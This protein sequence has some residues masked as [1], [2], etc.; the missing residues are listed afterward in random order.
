[1]YVA[2]THRGSETVTLG[3]FPY[4]FTRKANDDICGDPCARNRLP[5]QCNGLREPGR[6]VTPTH[7]F[8]DGVAPAL[9]WDVEVRAKSRV[10]PQSQEV[11]RDLL[12][13]K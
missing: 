10:V 8:Q 2:E 4:A 12:G 7:R 5:N 11:G 6:V 13:L 9:E 3:E 1:M